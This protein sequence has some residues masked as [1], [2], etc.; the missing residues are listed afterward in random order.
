MEIIPV[1][2]LGYSWR[3]N[4]LGYLSADI[5]SEKRTVFRERTSRKTVSFEEQIMSTH[6][7]P[8]FR[9]KWRLLCLFSFKS[10]LQPAQFK[11]GEY[12][13]WVNSPFQLPFGLRP[14]GL[15]TQ[16]PFGLEEIFPNFQNCACCENDLLIDDFK[17]FNPAL[18]QSAFPPTF[19]F[20]FIVRS[21]RLLFIKSFDCFYVQSYTP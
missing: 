12:G 16:S 8:H 4:M 19:S 18:G 15:L 11:T 6:K 9:P 10:F 21:V 17:H 7:Y 1:P 5:C 2:V 20:F 3:G 13:L 14:H